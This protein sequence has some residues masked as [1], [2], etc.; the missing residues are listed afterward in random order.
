LLN[1]NSVIIDN[2]NLVNMEPDLVTTALERVI[3]DWQTT[4]GGVVSADTNGEV[5]GNF[6]DLN[7]SWKYRYTSDGVLTIALASESPLLEIMLRQ[8]VISG[9]IW[10]VA[11]V[12]FFFISLLLARFASRPVARA[13]EQQR[14]FVADAS[15]ELKTPLTVILANNSLIRSDPSKTVGEQE[16]WIQSTQDEAQRMDGLVRDLLLLAQT[17]EDN[18]ATVGTSIARPSGGGDA[19]TPENPQVDLSALVERGLLQFDA[20]LFE[21]GIELSQSIEPGIKVAGDE[22]Q[23]ERLV[24][25]LLD[26][27]SKYAGSA[28]PTVSVSLHKNASTNKAEL[29][30]NNSGEPIAPDAIPHIFERFYRV[31]SAHSDAEGFGL[32]LS[33]AQAIVTEHAGS[34]GV[35]STAENGTT[36]TVT[37]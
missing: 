6:G 7:L 29:V 1:G 10:V 31:D 34:I 12:V 15:H 19:Q 21:R 28:K 35:S 27:A 8:T 5:N 18:N 36:F 14:Q 23:L 24:Q 33:L 3:A 20:V 2:S 9:V 30:V 4:T 22:E 26:N 37:L 11:M 25:I 16:Q 32:G 13:W 17:D